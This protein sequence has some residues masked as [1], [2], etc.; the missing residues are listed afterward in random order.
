MK[1]YS[2]QW[3][4]FAH[5]VVAA[6]KKIAVEWYKEN[7]NCSDADLNDFVIITNETKSFDNFEYSEIPYI[8]KTEEYD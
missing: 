1:V 4:T 6:S 8:L 5:Y 2:F 7:Q 3:C